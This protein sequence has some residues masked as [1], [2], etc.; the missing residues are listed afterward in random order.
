MELKCPYIKECGGCS[1]LDLTY[2]DE[3]KEKS[4]YIKKL[5]SSIGYN[6]EI[7]IIKASNPYYY[8]NKVQMAFKLSKSKKVVSGIYQE[9]SHNIIT[10][11]DC[12]I[13]SEIINRVLKSVNQ[14]FTKNKITPFV[15]GGIIKHVLVRHAIKTGE[16]MVV[17]VT[18]SDFFP[19]RN[20]FV[21]DLLALEP[22]ITTV[23]QNIQSRDTSIVLGPKERVIYGKGYIIDELCGLKFKLSP[24][25]FYQINPVQTEKLYNIAVEFANLRSGNIVIDAYSGIGTIGMVASKKAGKVICVENNPDAVKDAKFNA[26]FNKITN[27]NFYCEDST[28]FLM[29]L[30]DNK[31]KSDCIFL[32]PPRTGTTYKF[33]SAIAKMKIKRV[34]YVSCGPETLIRDLKIFKDCVCFVSSIQYLRCDYSI[35]LSLLDSDSKFD[36]YKQLKGIPLNVYSYLAINP[37]GSLAKYCSTGKLGEMEFPYE[38]K[39]S[40]MIGDDYTY[41]AVDIEVDPDAAEDEDY[42]EEA[43]DANVALEEDDVNAV[44]PKSLKKSA[45]IEVEAVEDFFE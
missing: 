41:V 16:I 17:I 43:D 9:H 39:V 11:N 2:E 38:S 15:N 7:E 36:D 23:V 33:I 34:V 32:D 6:K 21:K 45:E 22:K 29:N 27:V 28:K 30:A 12:L 4:L 14:A 35:S 26:T 24:R 40:Q 13:Q 8:R 25:S 3:I 20:N 5:F 37:N 42:T 19:G 18:P 44:V 1:Q 10:V 31:I